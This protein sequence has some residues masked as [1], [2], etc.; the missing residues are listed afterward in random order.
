MQINYDIKHLELFNLS[1]DDKK[2]IKTLQNA[3]LINCEAYTY[4]FDG[5]PLFATGLK[6]L[7]EYTG[8][9]WVIRTKYINQYKKEFVKKIQ[10]LLNYIIE[11]YQLK[12]IQTVVNSD[13]TK[14]IEFLG[15]ERECELKNFVKDEKL[16]L[17]RRLF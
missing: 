2:N 4:I 6:L 11:K 15:F 14:W 16:F 5:R 8:E 9:I 7:N 1:D 12:R 3:T 10:T 17:Y 13:W